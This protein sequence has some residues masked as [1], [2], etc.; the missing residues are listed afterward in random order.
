MEKHIL[1]EISISYS[2]NIPKDQ[3]K[4]VGSSLDAFKLLSELWDKKLIELQEEFKVLFLNRANE[5][6]GIYNVS[7]GGGAGTVVDAKLIFA[8]SLKC[9]A[10]AI[11][12]SHN[13]PSGNLKPS[14]ADIELTKKLKKAGEVL[15]TNVLDHLIITLDGY[16]SF[17][18]EGLM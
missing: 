5:V 7:K 18:D 1:S 9:N 3:R 12:L 13:H 15:D 17:A 4:Q 16:F 14:Q 6:L 2:C 8:T 10:H 11:I